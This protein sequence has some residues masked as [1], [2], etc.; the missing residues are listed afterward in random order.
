MNRVF[1]LGVVLFFAIVGIAMLGGQ[2]QAVAG[3]GCGGCAGVVACDGAVGC[4]GIVDAGCATTCQGRCFGRLRDRFN[5]CGGNRGRL[6]GQ[7]RCAGP[8]TDCCG[9]P[10]TTNCCGT[11]VTTGCAGTVVMEGAPTEATTDV[12]PVEEPK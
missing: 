3:H 8:A 10:V 12:A 2:E 7:R 11:V 4:G 1:V 6:F 9:T 5:R